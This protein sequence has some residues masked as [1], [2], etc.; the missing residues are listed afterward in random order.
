VPE[1][2]NRPNLKAD[3]VVQTMQITPTKP[4]VIRTTPRERK[5]EPASLKDEKTPKANNIEINIEKII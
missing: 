5:N 1:S 4:K 3:P 2:D